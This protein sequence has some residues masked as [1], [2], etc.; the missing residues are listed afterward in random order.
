[1]P[2]LPRPSDLKQGE[3]KNRLEDLG[4]EVV[5]ISGKAV[6]F[7]PLITRFQKASWLNILLSLMSLVLVNSLGYPD[8]R[9]NSATI[10][11]VLF[12]PVALAPV[13]IW[14]AL[15][16][17]ALLARISHQQKGVRLHPSV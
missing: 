2:T 4:K 15:Q 5:R 12:V 16:L 9:V 3:Y 10:L 17:N 6:D 13:A 7:D 1:L 8:R 14:T 11:S